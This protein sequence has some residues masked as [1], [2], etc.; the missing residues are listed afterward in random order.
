MYFQK[1]TS[2]LLSSWINTFIKRDCL[3]F[4]LWHLDMDI[5]IH[6]NTHIK[7]ATSVLKCEKFHFCSCINRFK[8][9]PLWTCSQIHKVFVIFPYIYPYYSQ[10]IHPVINSYSLSCSELGILYML[11]QYL[12]M[13]SHDLCNP[14]C[15]MR[16][17]T[18]SEV[19]SR[20]VSKPYWIIP[21]RF[22]YRLFYLNCSW[23]FY[24]LW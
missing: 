5:C 3:F 13:Q 1:Q 16:K 23:A 9:A 19:K 8:P 7:D 10:G 6:T 17:L 4:F 11:F 20:S 15:R 21:L 12:L 2:F 18:F 24:L 14:L 22:F